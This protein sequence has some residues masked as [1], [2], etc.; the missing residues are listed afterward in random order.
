MKSSK[1]ANVVLPTFLSVFLTLLLVG[2]ST[3]P[4]PTTPPATSPSASAPSA[5]Q[6]VS[7]ADPLPAWNDGPA[8]QAIIS[9]V[10][11]HYRKG[12]PPIRAA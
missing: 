12:Q 9:F 4:A 3:T 10:K 6:P 5:V 7:G 1:K 8:K 11:N 2:C